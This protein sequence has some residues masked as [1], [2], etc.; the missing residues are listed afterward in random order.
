MLRPITMKLA[1]LLALSFLL[2]ACGGGGSGSVPNNVGGDLTD[3][4]LMWGPRLDSS[5]LSPIQG[6][7]DE[8]NP[9]VI[10]ALFAAARAIPHGSS[11][12]SRVDASGRTAHE[13]SVRVIRDDDGSLGYLVTGDPVLEFTVPGPGIRE[14]LS[15]A[16]FTDLLPGIEPDLTTYPHSVFGL[17]AWNGGV[18]AFWDT[19]PSDPSQVFE[20]T[21]PM[22]TATYTGDAVGLRAADGAVTKFLADAILVADFDA[23]MMD[24]EVAGFRSLDGTS[25]GDL[26]VTLGETGFSPEDGTFSGE[27]S[28]SVAGSGAWGARWSDDSL[29]E[30]GGTFGFAAEDESV[31]ILGAFQACNCDPAVGDPGDS[32]SNMSGN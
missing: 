28:A 31:A 1:L 29:E 12:S 3:E 27:T 23:N 8:F 32:A 20:P 21:F 5:G 30:L 16:V 9:D 17:W 26:S 6:A 7:E 15:L 11:Q 25:L 10:D 4:P 14:G 19:S 22:G 2:C 13:M 24:G 18:G